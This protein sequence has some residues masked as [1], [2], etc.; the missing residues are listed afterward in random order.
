MGEGMCCR[1]RLLLTEDEASRVDSAV[2]NSGALSRALLVLEAV[3]FGLRLWANARGAQRRRS[4]RIEVR[5]PAELKSTVK[6]A[7]KRLGLTQQSLLRHFLFQYLTLSPWEQKSSNEGAQTGRPAENPTEQSET[8]PAKVELITV[9]DMP[10][11]EL[12]TRQLTEVLK[13]L[14]GYEP[15]VDGMYVDVIAR[16]A[17]YA[18]RI[19]AFIDSDSATVHTYSKVTDTKIKLIKT[20]EDAMRELALNRRDRIGN[21]AEGSLKK[22][23]FEALKRG[24]EAAEQSSD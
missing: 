22:E 21:Q 11:Y 9:K 1:V 24:L 3:Q 17:V 5:I 16:A 15:A 23:L 7:A 18:K 8:E 20:I 4:R 19:E 2:F 6:D 10:D 13:K 14:G 12:V